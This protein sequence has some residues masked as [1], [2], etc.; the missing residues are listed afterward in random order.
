MMIQRGPRRC[1]RVSGYLVTYK[2][3][4]RVWNLILLIP[5]LFAALPVISLLYVILFF[6]QGFPVF[7]KGRRLGKDKKPFDMYKFRTLVVGA[8]KHTKD[9]VLPVRSGLETPLGKFL[10]ESR[11]DELPQLFNVLKGEMNFIGPRPVRPEIANKAADKIKNYDIR[12]CVTPGLVGYTQLFMTHRTPKKIRARFNSYFCRRKVIFWKE[13]L[14]LAMTIMGM[15]RKMRVFLWSRFSG[16]IKK[17]QS[18]NRQLT[19]LTQKAAP[20][21]P[22]FKEKRFFLSYSLAEKK[23][24]IV[25]ITDHKFT[26]ACVLSDIDDNTFTFFSSIPLSE[27][28]SRFLLQMNIASSKKQIKAY[29]FGT[30]VKKEMIPGESENTDVKTDNGSGSG[31]FYWVCYKPVSD[32]DFYKIDKYFLNNSILC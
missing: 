19:A 25:S 17:E 13:P 20:L 21:K 18:E 27:G 9:C 5:V 23:V 31:Y 30:V 28:D 2:F 11:L 32:F 3:F 26:C 4:Y 29:C 12:F 7:Y 6:T 10:R 1:G 22:D 24:V 14:I 15:I 16:F 8:D